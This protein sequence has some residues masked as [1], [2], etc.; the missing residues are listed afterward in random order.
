MRGRPASVRRRAG[1]LLLPGLLAVPAPPAAASPVE[2]IAACERL[3]AGLA[4]DDVVGHLALARWCADR[5]LAAPR[6]ALLLHVI[7]LNPACAEAYR[8]LGYVWRDDLWISRD[9]ARREAGWSFREGRWIPPDPDRKSMFAALFRRI[10]GGDA[11]EER[12][13]REELLRI[14]QPEDVPLLRDRLGAAS[15]VVREAAAAALWR[16]NDPE[17][18]ALLVDRLLDP[19][20]RHA[21][22]WKALLAS[23]P[24]DLCV[25]AARLRMPRL[26][27]RRERA[28]I[29]ADGVRDLV[30]LLADAEARAAGEWL[31]RVAVEAAWTSAREAAV[32]ALARRRDP[33]VTEA[34]LALLEEGGPLARERA[35]DLLAALGEKRAVPL[36]VAS[37]QKRLA[38]RARRE[39]TPAAPAPLLGQGIAVGSGRSPLGYNAFLGREDDAAPPVAFDR[40]PPELAALHS[41][42]GKTFGEDVA[43]WRAWL[44]AAGTQ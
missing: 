16:T 14:V 24:R 21:A 32:A 17:A 39:E 3:R 20:D 15:A 27:D 7:D 29:S 36:L 12:A 9:D 26:F 6:V 31:Y 28:K 38:A 33:A 11:A 40:P 37:L 5:S 2:D 13:A 4:P 18:A 30:D 19:R 44:A 43:A 42:T 22:A 23:P 1:F 35:G 10:A 25:A 34:A 8:G 41:L